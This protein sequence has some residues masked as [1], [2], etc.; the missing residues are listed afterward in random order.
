MKGG[1][2]TRQRSAL[3]IAATV[4]GG[5][6][7][8]VAGLRAA[9]AAA[10]Q[11]LT[12]PGF[13]SGASGWTAYKATA[14]ATTHAVSGSALHLT[15]SGSF[16]LDQM[17]SA[18]PGATYNA[19]IQASGS[20]SAAIHLV[21][22]DDGLGAP[23]PFEPHGPT[24]LGPVYTV[25]SNSVVAPSWAAW[26]TFSVV[27]V[28]SSGADVD[29]AALVETAAPPTPTPTTAPTATP[30]ATVT[31]SPAT[32]GATAT[33]VATDTPAPGATPTRTPAST[34]T[35]TPT[36]TP[37]PTHTPTPRKQ[38]TATRTPTPAKAAARTATP[39][40]EST[41]MPTPAAGSSSS[42]FGGLLRN[43]DF[44]DEDNGKPA[45]WS[46]YG[47]TMSLTSEAYGGAWS[48]MLESDTSSTKWLYQ[49]VGVDPATWY[50]ARAMARAEGGEVFIRV[51]WY[52]SNDGSGTILDSADSN[53]SS[54]N[55][56]TP[57]STG[58][59]QAPARANS[60]RVRLMLRPSGGARAVF[61]NAEFVE[62]IAPD[63][64]S[65]SAAPPDPSPSE[66]EPSA[67]AHPPRA[68]PASPA[69]LDASLSPSSTQAEPG[70][71]LT[72]RLSEVL[73][74]PA[75]PGHD[76]AWEWVE[77]VN[78]GDGP[79]DTAGWRIG[80]GAHWDV[81]PSVEVPAG[82]YVVVAAKSAAVSAALVLRVGDGEIADGIRNGGDC[83]RLLAP[84]G[85]E[86]DAVSFGDDTSIFEPAPPAPPAGTSLGTRAALA[87][88]AAENWAVT[89]R[90]TP[91]EPNTFPDP[92]GQRTERQ[93]VVP[94][95][96]GYEPPTSTSA[97]AGSGWSTLTLGAA[98]SALLLVS[99]SF[100]FAMRELR[101]RRSRG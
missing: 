62:M 81:L 9:P 64:P 69:Q 91:G 95:G 31:K 44:E 53:M 15:G 48:A 71:P 43:G 8:L 11:L 26:V 41:P 100:A 28:D 4:A 34:R 27:F 1:S 45:G 22:Y 7:L 52:A 74:D 57:L 35:P 77:L 60:A 24:L 61:D 90:P 29:E 17:V 86:A 18:E 50:E 23:K 49:A 46:K 33:P 54:S 51:S 93:P 84:N 13:E 38:P 37:A 63:S 14:S 47:G 56:W 73:S 16:S 36:K 2:G 83:L 55:T 68:F 39:K 87:E 88:P 82:G 75:A 89:E 12:N 42:T 80:D 78:I 10:S 101:R 96:P 94:A 6:L 25:L 21:F 85:E 3:P 59:V 98:A 30:T 40:R 99:A 97:R 58:A 5:V 67:A 92:S 70:S 66:D 79:L 32:P 76:T 19:S 20:G 65:P 72:F